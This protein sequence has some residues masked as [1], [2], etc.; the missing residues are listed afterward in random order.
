MMPMGVQ[1]R[2]RP[3]HGL[4]RG[5]PAGLRAALMA[6]IV[7][8]GA[9][10]V[11]SSTGR[12]PFQSAMMR[13]AKAVEPRAAAEVTGMVRRRGG[14]VANVPALG[15][16][17]RARGAMPRRARG[18]QVT[19]ARALAVPR[20]VG[21]LVSLRSVPAAVSTEARRG[22]RRGAIIV[23]AKIGTG[24][25]RVTGVPMTGLRDLAVTGL[26]ATA[27]GS[28]RGV[29][30]VTSTEARTGLRQG[31]DPAAARAASGTGVRRGRVVT[32]AR[33]G[34]GARHLAVVV[35][36]VSVVSLR[37]PMSGARSPKRKKQESAS[38]RFWRAPA[39]RPVATP[40][41]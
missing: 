38:P 7:A 2:A 10:A 21:A 39:L 12:D 23:V 37:M 26:S 27:R 22:G 31:A 30:A 20:S 24:R 40:R 11:A 16:A 36:I 8:R 19:T 28:S 33:T 41:S 15:E 3:R 1:G 6:A 32:T 4:Q 34:R 13:M 17:R 14:S 35:P 9:R 18:V 25:P 29:R 5:L